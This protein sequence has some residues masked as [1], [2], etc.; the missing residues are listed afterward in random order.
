MPK[1]CEWKKSSESQVETDITSIFID[2][3]ETFGSEVEV[4]F[5]PAKIPLVEIEIRKTISD[6]ICKKEGSLTSV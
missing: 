3:E 4:L 2:G 5:Q 1:V 6:K